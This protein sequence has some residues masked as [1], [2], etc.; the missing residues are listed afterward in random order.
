[1]LTLVPIVLA[2][3]YPFLPSYSNRRTMVGRS[4][5]GEMKGG[6]MML[7]GFDAESWRGSMLRLVK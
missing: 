7:K 3:G 1:M 6:V 5:E 4:L 2:S